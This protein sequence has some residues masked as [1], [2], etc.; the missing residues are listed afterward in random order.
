MSD[1]SDA[2][3][4]TMDFDIASPASSIPVDPIDTEQ[5]FHLQQDFRQFLDHLRNR[6][7]FMTSSMGVLKQMELESNYYRDQMNLLAR[8]K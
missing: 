3:L 4:D 2:P 1:D 5:L 8:G 7:W 6:L